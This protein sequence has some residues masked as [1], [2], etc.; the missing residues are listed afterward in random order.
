M[1]GRRLLSLLL[2]LDMK[3][4]KDFSLSAS[5]G[6]MSDAV[7]VLISSHVNKEREVENMSLDVG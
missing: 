2:H 6:A 3:S 7:S 1:L 4:P 5:F